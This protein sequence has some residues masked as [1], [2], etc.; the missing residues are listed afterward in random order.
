MAEW[1]SDSGA[2]PELGMNFDLGQMLAMIATIFIYKSAVVCFACSCTL[3]CC[4]NTL[5]FLLRFGSFP[6]CKRLWGVPLSRPFMFSFFSLLSSLIRHWIPPCRSFSLQFTNVELE[7][8]VDDLQSDLDSMKKKVSASSLVSLLLKLSR[9]ILLISLMWL[10]KSVEAS[11]AF[12]QRK[13]WGEDITHSAAP[14][15]WQVDYLFAFW[16][17]PSSGFA[18]LTQTVQLDE[19]NNC[20]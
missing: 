3:F 15:F 9:Q 1:C 20:W 11:C 8:E 7:G 13:C 4:I 19:Q 14:Y 16:L 5:S 12:M 18:G 17:P 2:C 10:S 6:S